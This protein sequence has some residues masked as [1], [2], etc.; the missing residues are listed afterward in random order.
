MSEPRSWVESL[1]NEDLAFIRRF[2]LTSVSLKKM[3][4]IHGISYP[5]VRL[6]T[7]SDSE[8]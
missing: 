6:W 5:T 3:A 2:V 1:D 4:K 8:Y 7:P